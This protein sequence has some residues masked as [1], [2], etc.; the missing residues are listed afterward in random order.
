MLRNCI[1]GL[2]FAASLT[3]HAGVR[4][5]I[6]QPGQ[7][8]PTYGPGVGGDAFIDGR[9][10]NATI[11]D[12]KGSRHTVPVTLE[13]KY[14]WPSFRS[15]LKNA[16]KVNP[17][18]L[19]LSGVIGGSLAAVGWVM[20]PENTGVLMAP[21]SVESAAPGGYSF[22]ADNFNVTHQATSAGASCSGWVSKYMNSVGGTG[23]Q[24][25]SVTRSTDV[26]YVCKWRTS[27]TDQVREFLTHRLG[28]SCP[29]GHTYNPAIGACTIT[30]LVPVTDQ[31]LDSFVDGINSPQFAADSAPI[32]LDAVP[33]SFDYPDSEAFGGPNSIELP[34]VETTSLDQVS[35]DTVVKQETTTLDLV[36][37]KNPLSVTATPTTVTNT[38]Q[39]GTLTNTTT[40]TVTGPT[41]DAQPLP[42]APT[43][44]EFMPTVCE[45]LA[46]FKE[47]ILMP[48]VELPT[49]ED[50]DFEET[51]SASFGGG[52]PPPRQIALTLFPP[53]QFSWEPLCDFA[54]YLKFL[55]V[56]GAALMAAF[57]GLGIS[58]GNA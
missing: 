39:N 13:K 21:K 32:I 49:P 41:V 52:C 57:I 20:S 18:Q 23:Y 16:L 58:R 22:Y 51:Y 1:F 6:V 56:G 3:S 44:C 15:S 54:G 2:L 28:T 10:W 42:E 4:T 29:A 5:V 50:Q 9:D 36:Y 12:Q 24:F 43:D 7:L 37:S 53:V 26:M 11:S 25:L 45:W 33:G 31:D 19:A 8:V 34:A 48:D 38:Y 55:V 46:W 14:S 35:G 17:A 47:P 27:P 40:N 30:Q